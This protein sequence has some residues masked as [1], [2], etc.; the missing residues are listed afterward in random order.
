MTSLEMLQIVVFFGALIACVPL[1]GGYMAKVFTGKST[2]LSPIIHPVEY[3]IYRF[4]GVDAEHEQD[5]RAYVLALMLFNL[6]GFAV[7]FIL[8]LLQACCR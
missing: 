1:L 8:Q 6:L 4:S 3:A 7:L 2:L 5:W